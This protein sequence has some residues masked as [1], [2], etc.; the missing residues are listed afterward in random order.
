MT[1]RHLKIQS[2]SPDETAQ[3]AVAVAQ[4][5]L[6]GDAIFLEGPIG[7]GKSHFARCAIL[8]LLPFPED[9]PSP[10]Y[11]LVQT[12]P[13]S[14]TEVWHADLY[15]LGEP[16]EIHEL[17]LLAA[18]ENAICFVEWPDRLGQLMPAKALTIQ[19]EPQGEEHMRDL[20]FSWSNAR[21]DEGLKEVLNDRPAIA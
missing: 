18:F 8:S 14:T 16:Q 10:T 12:Y 21:W 20:I 11:T 2:S 7:A 4:L 15:R 5:L 19:F 6:P 1:T 9:I 3:I 13:T 17:G